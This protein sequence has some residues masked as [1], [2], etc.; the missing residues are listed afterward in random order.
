[1]S[2]PRIGYQY[3]VLRCVP[4]VDREEFLNVGVVVYSQQVDFLKAASQVDRARL[5]ALAP[6][7]DVDNVNEALDTIAAVCEGRPSAGA[8]GK[9]TLS[10][11][12]GFIASPRSTVVQPGPIHGGLTVDPAA[13]VGTLLA[14]LVAPP[15]DSDG[16]AR[17]R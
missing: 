1:M 15:P 16:D 8:P 6:A 2:D 4:R 11:R 14:R 12:F 10:A 5:A 3:V 9:A 7:L 17:P 13:E